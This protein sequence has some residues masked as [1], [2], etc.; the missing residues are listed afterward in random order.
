MT[1]SGRAP[2]AAKGRC[3]AIDAWVRFGGAAR[4]LFR[5][6]TPHPS[7]RPAASARPCRQRRGK[8]LNGSVMTPLRR[9]T[10]AYPA[11]TGW[12]IAA[13]LLLR[14]V[15]PG[16]WMLAADHGRWSIVPCAGI[17]PVAPDPAMPSMHAM[18]SGHD[19]GQRHD[20]GGHGSR[21]E[22]PCAFAGLSLPGLATAD[23]VLLAGLIVFVLLTAFRRRTKPTARRIS[24][25]R[26]PLRAPPFAPMTA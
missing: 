7:A 11:V 25:I 5:R 26:P 8:F 1:R 21:A 23:P 22:Q 20:G 15:M 2:A 24:R 14:L 3:T 19:R 4:R 13:A 18:S 16:G 10:R 6:S 9:L 12:L 17:M